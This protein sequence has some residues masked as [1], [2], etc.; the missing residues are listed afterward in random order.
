M[1]FE[2][3]DRK[4]REYYSKYPWTLEINYFHKHY[5]KVKAV[6]LEDYDFF[7]KNLQ[8]LLKSPRRGTTMTK[9]IN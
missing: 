9:T 5:N 1:A 3:E 8:E 2:R 7:K 6:A 4:I